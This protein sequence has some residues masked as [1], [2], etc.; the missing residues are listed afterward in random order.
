MIIYTNKINTSAKVILTD[1]RFVSS[2]SES[3]F[4]AVKG[5]RHDGHQFINELYTKGVREFVVE[6]GATFSINQK[7]VYVEKNGLRA[8]SE[9][10]VESNCVFWIVE[11]SIKALQELATSHR[12]KF[13][14]PIIGITG[15]N[16]K[17][18][19]KEWLSA[20]LESSLSVVKSPRSYNSQIGVALS[21]WQ[22]NDLHQ[23][24]IF[25]AGISQQGEMQQL[26]NILHPEYGIFTTIGSAHDEGFRSRKQKITEKL[27]LFRHSNY[28]VYCQ[29]NEEIDEEIQLFLKA[30]NPL[31][32]LIG[33]TTKGNG[34]HFV[35]Y[36]K[37]ANY[38]DCTL[39]FD[40]EEFSFRIPFFD[41]ASIQNAIHCAYILL[42]ML[43]KSS[44]NGTNWETLS[45]NFQYLKPVSMR[46][47]L[48]H[49]MNDN[50]LIDDTYNND[51]AGLEMALNF[52]NQHHT[53]RPKLLILSDIAESGLSESNLY[54]Q[55]EEVLKAK[56]IDEIIGIGEGISN[57]QPA[58]G[59][60]FK[61]T[62]E[63]LEA[64]PNLGIKSRFIL[65]KGARKFE[66]ERIVNR[67]I[68]KVH[69]T[70]LE[71]NLDSLT[72]NLNFYRSKIKSPTKLMVMVK[73]HAYGSGSSEIAALLQYHRVDYL[74]VAYTD[75][76]VHLRQNG[77]TLPI[78]VLN[79][80]PESYS[81]LTEY[82]L[83][84]EVYSLEMLAEFED[85]LN[86]TNLKSPVLIHLKLDT[87]MHRLGFIEADIET[88]ISR[89]QANPKLKIASIFS[90]LAGADEQEHNAFSNRQITV[91]KQLATKIQ[92]AFN[93]PISRHICNSA[94]IIRFPEAHFEMVRLGIG[95]YGIEATQEEQKALQVVATL[96]TTISQ[97]KYLKKG[98]TVGYSRR[99][100]LEKDATIAT[101]AIGYA[102]GFDR[103]FSRG[104][105]E[106][107]VHN[108]R[109]KTIGNVC[110]DMTM[111]D[112]TDVPCEIGDEVII[113][114]TQP[115]ISELATKIET[116]PYEI[117]TGVSERVKRVFY[118]E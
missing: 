99:G 48:K 85:F 59:S 79:P 90:H 25:E 40:G 17:T 108:Q 28:L 77:I 41:D 118:K 43:Q 8:E 6:I 89:I 117:L 38:T 58:Q 110:M 103:G 14:L 54:S 88:L 2:A 18:I 116:I 94:G 111:I 96:K 82:Q 71:V 24:G 16:G 70:V 87:G 66:F 21:V 30:V 69:G 22:I 46:L 62:T 74:G 47:E 98:E 35:S 113:F 61:S 39:Y 107:F 112:V 29:D 1:S 31:I 106:V 100:V 13:T 91:F 101:I 63:F 78:M 95:L 52:M 97:K 76:G 68:Q 80:Q 32:Q 50:Y 10:I 75:E 93:Y 7:E 83:E 49:G 37:Q 44:L 84:P 57:Y 64:L 4:F 65:I 19:V 105:G 27:R 42:L 36:N 12:N 115:T 9:Q 20:L 11:N 109:C 56:G 3:I 5:V 33:W 72:H 81:Y 15:S 45:T 51:L 86:F 23:I 114:G 26:E 34:I 53:K 55:V 92:S 73:A 102:D 104:V 60:Y 67:L